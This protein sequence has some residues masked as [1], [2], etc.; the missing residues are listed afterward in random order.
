MAHLYSRLP[1]KKAQHKKFVTR[2]KALIGV[3]EDTF[4]KFYYLK[5]RKERPFTT[6]CVIPLN[7]IQWKPPH[8]LH[9]TLNFVTSNAY[10]IGGFNG[11][12]FNEVF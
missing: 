8:L 11:E 4:K 3:N 6:G 9:S 1:T 5:T 10:C 7:S 2:E 12:G